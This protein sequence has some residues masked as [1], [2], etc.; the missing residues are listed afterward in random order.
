LH[1]VKAEDKAEVSGKAG[2]RKSFSSFLPGQAEVRKMEFELEGKKLELAR[3]EKVEQAAK[4]EKEKT[5][6]QLELKKLDLS[7]QEKMDQMAHAEYEEGLAILTKPRTDMIRYAS[8]VPAVDT[9]ILQELDAK[10][11]QF[12]M[13]PIYFKP[14]S[15]H[16]HADTMAGLSKLPENMAKEVANILANSH[17]ASGKKDIFTFHE[18]KGEYATVIYKQSEFKGQQAVAVLSYG[19]SFDCAKVVEGYKKVEEPVPIYEDVIEKT[20]KETNFLGTEYENVTVKKHVCT[21]MRVNHIPVFREEVL[22]VEKMHRVMSALE[23]MAGQKLV[24][25]LR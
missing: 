14:K 17:E 13:D 10:G 19:M 12:F 22:N 23:F 4:T 25:N 9:S 3:L 15:G 16:V 24:Q 11:F 21:E 8:E 1:H 6:L 20:V 5:E 2:L 18:G 7:H